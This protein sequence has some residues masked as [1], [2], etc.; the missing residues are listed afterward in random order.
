[1]DRYSR[2]RVLGLSAISFVGVAGCTG[3]D[4]SNTGSNDGGGNN[5]AKNEETERPDADGD[6]V[7][8]VQDDYPHDQYL[9]RKQTK[10]DTRKLEEDE[11][12]YYE[13]DFNSSGFLRYDFIVRD[14][15]KIDV[16]FIE[17]SEYS[18]FDNGDRYEYKPALSALDS[19]GEEV[20]EKVPEGTYY[21]IFDNSNRGEATPPSNLNN[22][23]ITVEFELEVGE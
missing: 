8:D 1:M 14:G 18:H 15:P 6:G 5:E 17:K 4:N 19:A 13:L 23:V 11:W 16:I 9:S 7:F 21:I 3:N 10:S 20:S 22:D 2:R 12:R